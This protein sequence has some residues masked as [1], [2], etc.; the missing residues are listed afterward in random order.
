MRTRSKMFVGALALVFAA[1]ACAVPAPSPSNLTIA[2][3]LLSDSEGDNAAG[4]D[5]NWYDFDIVTQAVVL[6]PDL[7]EAASDPKASLTAFLPNDRAFQ[8][9]VLDLTGKWVSNEQGVFDA[10]ASLGLPTVKTVLTYHL[11]PAK[12][13]ASD[14]LAADGAELPTLQ[15][16]KITVDVTE[17]RLSQIQLGDLDPND[18]DPHVVYS[19]YNYGGSLTNGY[20]HG[21]SLVLRPADL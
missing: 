6:Y 17:P 13:A 7:V 15:G 3:Q 2:G 11:I 5:D 20:I 19:K 1:S 4:F 8:V 12:I 16:G 10:V 21:I 18:D 14:A 9:L